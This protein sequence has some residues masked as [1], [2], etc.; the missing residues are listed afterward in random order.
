MKKIFYAFFVVAITLFS[1][2][3]I[4][5]VY[6][7]NK[8]CSLQ[9]EKAYK[10]KNNASIYYI[11]SSCTKKAFKNAPA[12]FLYFKSWKDVKIV[13][14]STL[15]KIPNDKIFLITKA[16]EPTNITPLATKPTKNN[17][18]NTTTP[19]RDNFNLLIFIDENSFDINDKEIEEYFNFTDQLLYERTGIHIKISTDNIWRVKV[20]NDYDIL[21]TMRDLAF[22]NKEDFKNANGFVFFSTANEDA[23]I[24]GGYALSFYPPTEIKFCNTFSAHEKTDKLYG[25]VI[26]WEHKFAKCGYGDSDKHTND[27][28]IGGE[29]SNQPGT[30]CILQNNYYICKNALDDYYATNPYLMTA[31]SIIHEIMHHFGDNGT[32]DHYGTDTCKKYD[33]PKTDFKCSSEDISGCYFNICPYAYLNFK[34]SNNLCRQ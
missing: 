30:K 20:S 19:N 21:T 31:S 12:F 29:C 13:S 34:N 23:K 10:I 25:A 32:M 18:I 1:L 28:S 6:S 22:K 17:S 33:V 26:D 24:Y 16:K 15:N 8:K 11:T 3:N 2:F 9:T 7:A 4:N 14:S 5:A 27:Y